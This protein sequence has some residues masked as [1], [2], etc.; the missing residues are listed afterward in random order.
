VFIA[1][2]RNKTIFFLRS[3]RCSWNATLEPRKR[4][5][6]KGGLELLWIFRILDAQFDRLSLGNVAD[7]KKFVVIVSKKLERTVAPFLDPN[8]PPLGEI[9]LLVFGLAQFSDPGTKT[10]QN[11]FSRCG[12]RKMATLLWPYSS[13]WPK[14]LWG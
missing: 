13:S 6:P 4:R 9:V 3:F 8:V 1:S 5:L 11:C 2:N 7:L 14:D 10:R 12:F